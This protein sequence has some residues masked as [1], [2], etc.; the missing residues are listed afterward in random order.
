MP[1]ASPKE[2]YRPSVSDNKS[3]Q[4]ESVNLVSQLS[5][6]RAMLE[7]A[8]L[9]RSLTADRSWPVPVTQAANMTDLF[10]CVAVVGKFFVS[11]L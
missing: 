3:A 9:I 7:F 1:H 11:T 4:G 8:A 6:S 10:R 5:S 2:T